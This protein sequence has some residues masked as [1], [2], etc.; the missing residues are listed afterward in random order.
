MD[1][2]DGSL[3]APTNDLDELVPAHSA[4]EGDV[5]F[6]IPSNTATAGIQMGDVGE[7]K[8]T[9]TINLHK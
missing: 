9:T 7:G 6:I 1:L 5:E 3:Q 4:K 2:I 8:P